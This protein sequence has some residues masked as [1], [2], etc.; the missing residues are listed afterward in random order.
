MQSGE[1]WE[2]GSGERGEGLPGRGVTDGILKH[3]EECQELREGGLVGRRLWGRRNCSLGVRGEM[4]QGSVSLQWRQKPSA[5]GAGDEG[6]LAVRSINW[7]AW[8][9]SLPQAPPRWSLLDFRPHLQGYTG[10]CMMRVLNTSLSPPQL[11]G[12]RPWGP[13]RAPSRGVGGH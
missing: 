6:L 10:P 13:A 5:Q 12:G 11:C 7:G 1:G 3:G 8:W 2:R 9:Q 4:G